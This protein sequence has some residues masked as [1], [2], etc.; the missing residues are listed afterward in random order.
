MARAGGLAFCWRARIGSTPYSGS[1]RPLQSFDD[2]A[3]EFLAAEKKTIRRP[4]WRTRRHSD[5]AAMSL[6]LV[7]PDKPQLRG[8]V[9]VTVHRRR[10]PPKYGFSLLFRGERLAGLDVNPGRFHRNLLDGGSVSVT[11]WQ[12]FPLMEAKADDRELPFDV[13]L[14][15]FLVEVCVICNRSHHVAAPPLESGQQLELLSGQR[16]NTR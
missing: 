7:V 8:R 12:R 4:R 5:H 10:K 2:R 14:H 13:W 15:Q 16:A 1:G 3:V 6:W 9:V 11:H